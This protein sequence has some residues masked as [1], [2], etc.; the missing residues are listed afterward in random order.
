VI[1]IDGAD[2]KRFDVEFQNN[3]SGSAAHFFDVRILRNTTVL[4]TWNDVNLAFGGMFHGSYTA[5]T[6]GGT[7]IGFTAEV[8]CAGATA[9]EQRMLTVDISAR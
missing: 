4:K 6:I 8:R 5:A 3:D 1:D 2:R 9:V 7:G